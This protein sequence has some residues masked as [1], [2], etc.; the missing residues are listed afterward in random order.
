MT[1]LNIGGEAH[2]AF[3]RYKMPRLVTKFEG[4]GNG[5]FTVLTNLADVARALSRPTEHLFKY[6]GYE[7]CASSRVKAGR[8]MVNGT[9]SQARVEQILQGF[10]DRY[11]LCASCGN[12]ETSLAKVKARLSMTCRACG[13]TSR[14]SVDHRLTTFILRELDSAEATGLT[15]EARRA[16]RGANDPG[17]SEKKRS[18]E[19]VDDEDTSDEAAGF[20]A[21]VVEMAEAARAELLGGMS[22]AVR[23][24][25]RE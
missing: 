3:Y 21:D 7:L 14:V 8:W 9:H 25:L 23:K 12:P 4:A 2:D 18:P 10:V 22:D 6:F 11:V 19:D 20:S 13:A 17:R 16:R 24:M 5:V 1:T 15:K